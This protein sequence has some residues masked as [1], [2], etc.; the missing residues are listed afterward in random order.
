VAARPQI[1]HSSQKLNYGVLF[2]FGVLMFMFACS[3]AFMLACTFAL[4]G[5]G[6]DVTV[7]FA[8]TLTFVFSVV[9][10]V[11]ASTTKAIRAK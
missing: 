1:V 4:A 10:H 7:V 6:D 11:E 5:L 3:L 8:L 2:G 9:A